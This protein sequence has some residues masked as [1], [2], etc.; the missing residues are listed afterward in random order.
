[1]GPTESPVVSHSLPNEEL[2]FRHQLQKTESYHLSM[3]LKK[4]NSIKV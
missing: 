2:T 1:M 4:C 3:I